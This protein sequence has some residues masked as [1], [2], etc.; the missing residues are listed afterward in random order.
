M[1]CCPNCFT[2]EGLK[3]HIKKVGTSGTCDFCKEESHYCLEC[4]ELRSLFEPVIS[5]YTLALDFMHT[6]QL[7]EH[8]GS[9]LWERLVDDWDIFDEYE[10]AEKILSDIFIDDYG[11]KGE[12]PWWRGDWVE[13]IDDFTGEDFEYCHKLETMW[14]K[15]SYEL[16][17]INRFFPKEVSIETLLLLFDWSKESI[18]IDDTYY[19]ARN[20]KWNKDEMGAPTKERAK[21]GRANPEGVPYLYLSNSKETCIA[22]IRPKINSL[23]SVGTFKFREP[24]TIVDISS[25]YLKSPFVY[26]KDFPKIYKHYNFIKYMAKKISEPIDNG[27]D[28]LPTQYL[29]ELIKSS[30]Y[31]GILFKSSLTDGKNLT[32]FSEKFTQCEHVEYIRCRKVINE[33]IALVRKYLV[34]VKNGVKKHE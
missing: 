10:K 12:Q 13:I 21:Q 24:A 8:E 11:R 17:H 3:Q 5:I 15:F 14:E 26:G 22:E 1:L 18:N 29:C 34:L 19:R 20:R 4:N 27:I 30:G 6:E 2:D 31:D 33:L 7:K 23:V 28:Y 16:K 9:F 32:M 25:R